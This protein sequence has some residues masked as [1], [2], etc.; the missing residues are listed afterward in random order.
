MQKRTRRSKT[1]VPRA[2]VSTQTYNFRRTVSQVIVL[3]QGFGFASAGFS[4]AI[5]FSL[6]Q[7][8]IWINGV[9]T[10]STQVPNY[11]E[12]TALFDQYQ[13]RGV[14]FEIY[15]SKNV[16]DGATPNEAVPMIW[17][18]I[19]YDDNAT[20]TIAELSQYPGVENT[21]LGENGGRV[22]RRRI[23]PRASYIGNDGTGADAKFVALEQNPWI[24][25]TYP[26]VEHKGVKL[27]LDTYELYPNV[28]MGNVR[29]LAKIDLAFRNVR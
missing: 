7:M 3:N 10:F 28:T 6:G 9:S 5:S 8:K 18:A 4:S 12:F 22:L 20:T 14:E 1:R 26:L 11:T 17:H 13:L 25:C 16:V 23:R 21:T 15:W 19:D 24:D 29:I 27:F 2:V